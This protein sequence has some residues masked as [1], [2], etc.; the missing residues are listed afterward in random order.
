MYYIYIIQNITN[1]K[2]YVGQ[3]KNLKKRWQGH[4]DKTNNGDTRPLYNSM[5]KHGFDKFEMNM[6]EEFDNLD[7]CNE[8]EEFWIQFFQSQN[9]EIGYNIA[10]GGNNHAHTS[11]TKAKLS[12]I[13]TGIKASEETKKK[14]SEA[15]QGE[16]NAMFGRKHSDETIV[17]M[18]QA[19]LGKYEGENNPFYGKTHTEETRKILSEN[20]IGLQAGESNPMFGKTHTEEIRQLL[21]DI[22]KGNQYALGVKHTEEAKQ[23]IS[24]S[25]IGKKRKPFSEETKRKMSEIRKGKKFPRK[26]V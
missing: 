21:S 7:D 25:K 15:R 3:A 11:E 2:I 4:R 16:K 26:S 13:R 23:K 12:K 8:A 1:N 19:K 14:M 9:K 22:N 6:I 5:R 24:L 20:H 10:F 17:K 18:R